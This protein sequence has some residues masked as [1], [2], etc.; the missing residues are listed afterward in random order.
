MRPADVLAGRSPTVGK[1]RS[2]ARIYVKHPH[3]VH[4]LFFI[5]YSVRFHSL[6]FY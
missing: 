6:L 3:P 4:F 2:V 5:L 1:S